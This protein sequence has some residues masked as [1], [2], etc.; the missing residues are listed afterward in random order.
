M[1]RKPILSAIALVALAGSALA[2]ERAEEIELVRGDSTKCVAF[3]GDGRSFAIA[4]GDYDHK[5]IQFCAFSGAKLATG[6]A[7]FDAPDWLGAVCLS[8]DGKRAAVS[9]GPRVFVFSAPDGKKV[10]EVDARALQPK[11][12][13]TVR[14]LSLAFAGDALLVG[15]DKGAALF[16][17][18][19]G[20]EKAR[21][22]GVV[23]VKGVTLSPDGKE[24]GVAW[25]A[26]KE[27]FDQSI[28][29][30]DAKSRRPKLAAKCSLV[31]RVVF[32]PGLV[33][34]IGLGSRHG[35]DSKL[36]ETDHQVTVSFKLAKSEEEIGIRNDFSPDGKLYATFMKNGVAIFDV[37][38]EKL[39]RKISTK[40]KVGALGFSPDGKKLVV[41][42]EDGQVAV[43][44]SAGLRS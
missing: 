23:H 1:I 41:V 13:E 16:D 33:S 38:S 6:S 3:S 22:E 40:A 11:D 44:E 25:G 43:H 9:S 32:G 31:E 12:A 37:A 36:R 30:F 10:G 24:I 21:L 14:D 2:G 35:F 4:C 18:A 39:L 26:Y 20:K 5:R 19:T 15:G 7:A 17:V 28:T 34:G 27:D 42:S 29:I 8:S